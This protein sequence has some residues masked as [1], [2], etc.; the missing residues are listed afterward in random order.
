MKMETV[1][2]SLSPFEACPELTAVN[3]EAEAKMV[4]RE[5]AANFMVIN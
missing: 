3:A 5:R 4:A 1:W 2:E